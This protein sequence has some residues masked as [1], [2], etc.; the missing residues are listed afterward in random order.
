MIDPRYF[1]NY[2]ISVSV[3][4]VARSLYAL[5]RTRDP[6]YLLLVCYGFLH[7]ALLTPIRFRAMATLTNTAWG[8]RAA[9]AATQS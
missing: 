3:M 6:R 2:L 9:R 5:W 1:L 7:L 8:T 4:A